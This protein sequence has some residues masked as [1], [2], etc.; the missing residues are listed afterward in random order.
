MDAAQVLREALAAV[1]AAGV[2]AELRPVAF[3]K[4]VDMLTAGT[5]VSQRP[6]AGGGGSSNGGSSTPGADGGGGVGTAGSASLGRVATGL[7]IPLELIED[8]FFE[9]D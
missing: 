3:A 7:G 8:Y 2:P 1:E 5:T 6:A 4:T 9:S